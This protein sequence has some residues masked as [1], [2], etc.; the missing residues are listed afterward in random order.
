MN[1]YSDAFAWLVDPVHWA[2]PSGIPQRLLEHLGYTGLTLVIAIVIALPVGLYIGHTGRG[3]EIV[4]PFTG[5]LRALP[6][7][8]LVILLALG[9]GIGI[10]P[11]LIALVILALPPIIA[12][13]YSGLESVDRE[14]V[15]AARSVGFTGSGVLWQVEVPLALPLIVGGIRSAC[16]Q[17]IATW[18]VAAFLP[19]GGLG[20]FLYDALPNQ[21]YAQLLAGS[22]LVIVLALLADGLFAIVQRLVT[23]RGVTAGR[24]ADIR[25]KTQSPPRKDP[26]W[27]APEKA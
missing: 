12:G 4:V 8:G 3:R 23:P 17:V 21:D 27:L 10:L 1:S 7:L 5:A 20:R 9:L 19:L 13:A 25:T 24:T 6:T 16:L 11:P 22:I 14:V 15:D 2:G 26:S 18:T